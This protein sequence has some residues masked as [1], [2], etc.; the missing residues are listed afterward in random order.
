M[1]VNVDVLVILGL[2]VFILVWVVIRRN[3]KD[4]K[5]MEKELNAREMKPEKHDEEHI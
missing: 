4:Q 2:V 3:K 5:E 1:N